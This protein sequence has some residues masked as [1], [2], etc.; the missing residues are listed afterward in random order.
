MLFCSRYHRGGG[1]ACDGSPAC[2]WPRPP[3]ALT[4]ASLLSTCFLRAAYA[5]RGCGAS[6]AHAGAKPPPPPSAGKLDDL[7][8]FDPATMTWTL[9]SGAEYGT[10]PLAR[11]AHGFTSVGGTLYVHGGCYGESGGGVLMLCA[12]LARRGARSLP[13]ATHCVVMD[14][15]CNGGCLGKDSFEH[16]WY[17]FEKQVISL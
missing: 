17:M 15:F 6:R 4:P 1:A 13:A 3:S 8:S 7:Y 5:G 12:K 14:L 2:P 16:G 9:L 10:R 11:S